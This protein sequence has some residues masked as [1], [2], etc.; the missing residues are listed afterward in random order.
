MTINYEDMSPKNNKGEY[1]GKP[2]ISLKNS[3]A[4]NFLYSTDDRKHVKPTLMLIIL[5]PSLDK[6]IN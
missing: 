5:Q 2:L 6:E 3:A 1:K 4:N